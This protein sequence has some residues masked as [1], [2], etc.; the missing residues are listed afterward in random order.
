MNYKSHVIFRESLR[1]YQNAVK[2]ER[3]SYFPRIVSQGMSNPKVLFATIDKVLNPPKSVLVRPSHDLCQAFLKFFVDK[4]D[5]IRSSISG[6]GH[7]VFNIIERSSLPV[8]SQFNLVSLEQLEGIVLHLKSTTSI[9]DVLPTKLL[10]EA[11]HVLG[12]SILLIINSRLQFG[13]VPLEFKRAI[14][15]PVLKKG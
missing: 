6:V 12:P 3:S 7:T 9:Y 8:L 10:K 14:I 11:M 5:L 13:I 2:S 4:V 15:E 1:N